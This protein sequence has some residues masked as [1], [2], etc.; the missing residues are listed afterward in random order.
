V[1]C[2]EK[3]KG[4]E[5]YFLKRATA[6]LSAHQSKLA[7]SNRQLTPALTPVHRVRA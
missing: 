7:R 3:E 4:K 5:F 2:F 1:L 6:P